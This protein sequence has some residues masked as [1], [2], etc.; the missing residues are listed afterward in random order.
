LLS[1]NAKKKGF[2]IQNC[3]YEQNT[4]TA[5]FI[6]K[7]PYYACASDFKTEATSGSQEKDENMQQEVTFLSVY[8][9]H[10]PLTR[11]NAQ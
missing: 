9:M 3:S 7:Y 1:L 10:I 2:N 5:P 4:V 8:D 11:N 6:S